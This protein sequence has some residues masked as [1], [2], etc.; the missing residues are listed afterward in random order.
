VRAATPR[1]LVVTGVAGRTV[2]VAAENVTGIPAAGLPLAS[3]TRTDGATAR[4]LFTTALWP[5]PP[6]IAIADALPAPMLIAF[7]LSGEMETS[8]A[9]KR[10][11]AVPTEPESD[12]PEKTAAPV[13][14]FTVSDVVP[15]KAMLLFVDAA[16]TV[17]APAA[18]LPYWS[19][20]LTSGC[21]S[22]A[23]VDVDVVCIAALFVRM[24]LVAEAAVAV[25]E[26]LVLNDPTDA[27]TA[28]DP[29]AV[30]SE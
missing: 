2:P 23:A 14:A 28:P 30:P 1:A 19:T 13:V 20:T 18:A 25:K 3:T 10:I 17:I 8:D 9:V 16:V 12:R 11:E 27:D 29:T 21:G 26:K 15:F 4:A 7:V 5:V 24:I 6:A 22:S